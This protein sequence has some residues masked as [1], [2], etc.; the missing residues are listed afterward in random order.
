MENSAP[1]NAHDANLP[2]HPYNKHR[3]EALSDGIFAVT[4][5]LLVIE[6]KLPEHG[7]IQTQI[8]LV[9]A[10]AHLTPKFLSWLISFLV[11]SL[12]WIGHHR[13][14]HYVRH[15]DGKFLSL[16][17]VQLGIA[18]LMPFSSSLTG[19]YAG[20]IF[21]QIFY[22]INMACLALVALLMARYI[23]RHH[24]L[25]VFPMPSWVYKSIRIRTIGVMIISVAAIII[26][27]RFPAWG[28]AAFLLMLVIG[29]VVRR[30]EARNVKLSAINKSTDSSHSTNSA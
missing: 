27:S 22:S 28:N 18:S 1:L 2:A 14:F 21:S 6:L 23:F 11:L 25:T 19:E 12:F 26:A 3:I 29:L 30:I 4:M 24:E 7:T 16:C 8:D 20:A 5:T 15:V 10:V 9:S 17:L 13:I